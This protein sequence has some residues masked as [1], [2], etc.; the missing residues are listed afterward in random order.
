MPQIN[1]RE[2][3]PQ[4]NKWISDTALTMGWP[5]LNDY[6]NRIYVMLSEM[7]VGERFEIERSVHPDNY[8][9]FVRCACTAIT[10][11]SSQ[12]IYGWSMNE[13]ATII[14]RDIIL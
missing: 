5:E 7:K 4:D 14:V 3:I 6:Y 10:E 9:L 12:G 1:L 13:T 8:P 2:F 11:L